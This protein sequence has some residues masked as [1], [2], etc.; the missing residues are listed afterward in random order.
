MVQLIVQLIAQLTEH[1]SLNKHKN[2]LQFTNY[3]LAQK[4]I[5][6]CQDR[7][8]LDS[9]LSEKALKFG[10][11]LSR[12]ELCFANLFKR[13]PVYHISQGFLPV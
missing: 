7:A 5:Q 8:P 3:F 13:T 11:A 6:H 2:K 4:T 10:S 1:P 9:A 12:I